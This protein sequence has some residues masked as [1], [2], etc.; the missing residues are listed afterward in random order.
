MILFISDPWRALA[1]MIYANKK[2]WKTLKDLSSDLRIEK[3]SF[4][5]S[6]LVLLEDLIKY[7]PSLRAC[8]YLQISNEYFNPSDA[9]QVPCLVAY[10][11]A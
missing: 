3:E 8:R 1:D 9:M 2:N 7:Y 10:L 6:D 11:A 5:H 4:E